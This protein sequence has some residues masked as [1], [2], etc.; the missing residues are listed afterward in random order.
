MHCCEDQKRQT[1]RDPV[2]QC[3]TFVTYSVLSLHLH[4]CPCNLSFRLSSNIEMQTQWRLSHFVPAK[5]HNFTLASLNL[6]CVLHIAVCAR[7]QEGRRRA[8]EYQGYLAERFINF[9]CCRTVWFS[10]HRSYSYI[11][12]VVIECLYV[13][14]PSSPSALSS[15]IATTDLVAC[16]MYKVIQEALHEVC[17][18]L[19]ITCCSPHVTWAM[20]WFLCRLAACC[21]PQL[22]ITT[23]AL[24]QLIDFVLIHPRSGALS[25][26]AFLFCFLHWYRCLFF[27]VSFQRNCIMINCTQSISLRRMPSCF[28]CA[29]AWEVGVYHAGQGS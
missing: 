27:Y 12:F 17:M 29:C 26:G 21:S 23:F 7:A 5:V 8:H 22:R 6:A 24:L 25:L 4:N 2:A 19:P 9:V 18:R 3:T 13:Q 1:Q 16:I 10:H 14:D 15:F 28:E 11:T 20:L